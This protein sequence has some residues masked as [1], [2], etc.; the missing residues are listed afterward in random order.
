MSQRIG[1]RLA[2]MGFRKAKTRDGASAIIWDEK[3]IELMKGK[4]GLKE[5]SVSS[6]MQRE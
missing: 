6:E 3:S 2:A 1:R 5:T 4:Y